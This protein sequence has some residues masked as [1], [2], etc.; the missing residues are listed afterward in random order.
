MNIEFKPVTEIEFQTFFSKKEFTHNK[1][2]NNTQY[3][4]DDVVVG[5]AIF[6]NGCPK[7]SIYYLKEGLN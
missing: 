5:F 3:I 2:R 1:I 6:D 4:V 7:K